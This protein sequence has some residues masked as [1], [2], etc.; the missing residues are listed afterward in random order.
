ME[1][2]A[3]DIME[4][5][6]K[7]VWVVRAG[8]D[9]V[10]IE[11]FRRLNVVAIGWP[12]AGDLTRLRSRDEIASA[13]ARGLPEYTK[14]QL[15]SNTGQVSRFRFDLKKGETVLCYEPGRRVYHVG[16][17][18]G[19]YEYHPQ[20]DRELRNTRAVKWTG[21]VSRD[22][23][24]AATRNSL[25]SISTL[26]QA[27]EAAT[28]EVLGLLASAPVREAQP[29]ASAPEVAGEVEV[30]K[31]TEQ[32]AKEFL[33][34]R[35]SKLRWDQMQDLVAGVLRAMGYKTRI[36]PTGPDRG[37][38]ILASPDGLGFVAPRIVVEVKHRKETMGAEQ[39]RA[40]A[41]GLRNHDTGLYV[42][43]G[44][45]TKEAKY[46]AERAN[47]PITL[48]DAEDLTG[49]ITENYDR[50]DLDARTILPLKK[51]WWPA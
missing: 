45:F 24:S 17:I 6:A 30:R 16:T 26:F 14:S 19:D 49:V 10:F 48:M 31:D 18:E 51:I 22:R 2:H 11:D 50:M 33:Q 5:M 43:T 8:R 3:V 7:Q 28:V 1:D 39:I 34:D 35:L 47:H 42:S 44:G 40:F 20:Y 46:E 37:K 21:E 25:G 13:L 23:L 36:S 12:E 15:S 27:S 38:D 29:M 9:A 41:G 4:A 32:K